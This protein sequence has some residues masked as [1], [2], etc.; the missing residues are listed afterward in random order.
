MYFNSVLCKSAP[1]TGF[2]G[3]KIWWCLAELSISR[4][5][6]IRH[7]NLWA[8]GLGVEIFHASIQQP[9]E[10]CLCKAWKGAGFADVTFHVQFEDVVFRLVTTVMGLGG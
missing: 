3:Y 7:F 5:I 6:L 10:L 2:T 4:E 9:W 1:C 8:F